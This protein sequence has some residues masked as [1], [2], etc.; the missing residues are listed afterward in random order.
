MN[1]NTYL[2]CA[3]HDFRPTPEEVVSKDILFGRLFIN[4]DKTFQQNVPSD[5]ES[6]HIPSS[7]SDKFTNATESSATEA[8]QEKAMRKKPSKKKKTPKPDSSCELSHHIRPVINSCFDG[9]RAAM[10]PGPPKPTAP[11]L[12]QEAKAP[13]LLPADLQPPVP[14]IRRPPAHCQ[15]P[16]D[17][18]GTATTAPPTPKAPSP[19]PPPT[20]APAPTTPTPPITD[21]AAAALH[22][23]APT[24]PQQRQRMCPGCP[25]PAGESCREEAPSDSLE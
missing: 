4:A 13:P 23:V 5:N 10:M 24:T 12:A 14:P 9:V 19:Q 11:T 3:Q 7:N 18:T 21:A 16:A 1:G 8:E 25:H 15:R 2:G 22:L 6:T 20:D 17:G